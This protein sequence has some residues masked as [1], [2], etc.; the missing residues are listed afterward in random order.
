MSH[1]NVSDIRRV[2]SDLQVAGSIVNT[3]VTAGGT[4]DTTAVNG[5]T[6]DRVSLGMPSSAVFA[7]SARATM[8]S[9][10]TLKCTAKFQDSANDSDWT[11]YGDA[12]ALTTI[13][14]AAG[15][16]ATAKAGHLKLGVDLTGA[17]RYVR[18][19]VQP[20]MSRAGTDTA[21]IAAMVLLGGFSATPRTQSNT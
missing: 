12:L 14:T 3:A 9:G 7:I 5:A 15:G 20:D 16:A 11:D 17:R 18:A 8:A 21:T 10:E 13:V 1:G 4:G 2:D 6:I 19:V